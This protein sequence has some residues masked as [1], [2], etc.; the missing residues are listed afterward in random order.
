MSEQI[1]K[2]QVEL[3]NI[4]PGVRKGKKVI[5]AAGAGFESLLFKPL[6]LLLEPTLGM[7]HFAAHTLLASK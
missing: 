3:S 5:M 1:E 7:I 6:N 2:V 4:Q